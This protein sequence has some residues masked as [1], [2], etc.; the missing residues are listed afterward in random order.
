MEKLGDKAS[1]AFHLLIKPAS[2]L[3]K[4]VESQAEAITSSLLP[5]S[6]RQHR[7]SASGGSGAVLMKRVGYGVVGAAYACMVLTALLAVA[8]VV[9]VGTVRMW[10][11]EP[12]VVREN[13]H[14]DYTE[15]R[16]EASFSFGSGEKKR[17]KGV[18]VGHTCYVSVVL[19]L[20]ESDYNRHVGV[21]QLTAEVLSKSGTLMAR[22]THPC[23]LQFRSW[24]IRMARTFLMGVPILLGTTLEAQKLTVD[25]LT[26]HES[27]KSGSLRTGSVRITLAPRAG[28]M[29][30]PELYESQILVRSRL[31]WAKRLVRSWKWTFYVWA[32]IYSYITLLSLV[33][34][35]FRPLV[36]PGRAA[37][38]GSVA[39]REVEERRRAVEEMDAGTLRKW[40]QFRRKRKAEVLGRVRAEEESGDVGS[41]SVMSYTVPREEEGGGGWSGW[42]EEE[43]A[44]SSSICQ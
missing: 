20:P 33:L 37:V 22:S 1:Q 40:Q 34:C 23:M 10:V 11:E 39:R 28:T 5:G 27:G 13:L 16:P 2:W 12:V 30:L 32:S 35:C 3:T 9:G 43:V 42:D 6:R 36:F 31:P 26:Y 14:F 38:E 24:P 21:F 7:P 15:F 19:L 18:P 25:L 29:L 17:L 4:T 41:S 44:D 8:V